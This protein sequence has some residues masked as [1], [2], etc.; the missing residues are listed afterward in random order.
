MRSNVYIYIF[1]GTLTDRPRFSYSYST[2][3][4]SI[5]I[6]CH[7][8]SHLG[9]MSRRKI[10]SSLNFAHRPLITRLTTCTWFQLERNGPLPPI[11]P[12]NKFCSRVMSRRPV[13]WVMCTGA[14]LTKRRSHE[15]LPPNP[16][17]P[18]LLHFLVLYHCKCKARRHMLKVLCWLVVSLL[19]K[20]EESHGKVAASKGSFVCLSYLM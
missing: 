11:L 15:L 14:A 5:S 17:P 9:H 3:L 13:C 4:F 7:T 10:L 16:F 12:F 18:C 2:L 6:L 19:W 8:L 1:N 20:Q